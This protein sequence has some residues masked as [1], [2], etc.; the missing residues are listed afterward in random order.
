MSDTRKSLWKKKLRESLWTDRVVKPT[1]GLRRTG[2]LISVR[3]TDFDLCVCTL[4][5]RTFNA[6]CFE[7]AHRILEVSL[8]TLR[9]MSV[10]TW[11]YKVYAPKN[12]LSSDV[13]VQTYF[14]NDY[15]R[16]DA[17]DGPRGWIISR[18]PPRLVRQKRSSVM[19]VCVCVQR[20]SDSENATS[21]RVRIKFKFKQ[22]MTETRLVCE[23]FLTPFRTFLRPYFINTRWNDNIRCVGRTNQL[24]RRFPTMDSDF[25]SARA[26]QRVERTIVVCCTKTLFPRVPITRQRNYT[27]RARSIESNCFS[28][29][30][31]LV[32][33]NHMELDF[34]EYDITP[35]EI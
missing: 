31:W 2:L 33:R 34:S 17:T 24:R 29:R 27:V 14:P 21:F 25:T 13:N 26:W 23:V 20:R 12:D 30:F 1:W 6:A 10:R 16:G 8:R 35:V 28:D 3:S 22:Q 5:V 15:V 9:A 7:S 19:Y 11:I 32:S 18:E 4:T